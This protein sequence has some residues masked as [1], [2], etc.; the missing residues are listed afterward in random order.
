MKSLFMKTGTDLRH[1]VE[2]ELDWDPRLD[3]PD[4]GVAVNQGIVTLLGQVRSYAERWAAQDAAQSVGGVKALA[5]EIE[6][7]LPTEG[8]RSDTEI[9][10]AALTALRLNMS[11]PVV[12][13]KLAVHDGWLTLTGQVAFWYQKQAAETTVR[14]VQ[15]VKG[16]ANEI[17]VKA[18][19]STSDI[20]SRIEE[21]FRR[22][23]QID[24]DKIRLQVAGGTVTLEGEVE[25]WWERDHAESAVWAAPGVTSVQDR[26]IVRP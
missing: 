20:K 9:A 2:Q 22:H 23:A 10:E 13:I 8:E 16:I 25:S 26:L 4:I 19:V 3:G 14:N 7:K 17:T 6:V 21:A 24:A 15:G 1:D 18:L 5:N 11:V 12:D